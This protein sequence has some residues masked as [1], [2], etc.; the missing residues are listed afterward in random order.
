MKIAIIGSRTFTDYKL[1]EAT[2]NDF[3]DKNNVLITHVVSGGAKG[4]DKLG[5]LFANS[6]HAEKMIFYPDWEKHKKAAGFIRNKDIVDNADMIFAFW[7]GVS[8]G[9]KHSID[10]ALS[11]NKEVYIR[12][13]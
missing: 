9:T 5:E 2:L 1:L 7:D 10:Y 8:R 11:Q 12:L 6:I 3:M 13:F 4:A